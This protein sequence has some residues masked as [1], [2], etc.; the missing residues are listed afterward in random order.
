MV[1]ATARSGSNLLTDGLHAT[2]KAGRPKQFFL[3]KFEG[4]YARRLG[5]DGL[6]FRGYVGGLLEAASTSNR[7]FGFKVMAWYLPEFLDRVK[8]AFGRGETVALP[9][10]RRAFPRLRFIRIRRKNRLQQ[11]ISKARAL[12]SGLWKVQPGAPDESAPPIYNRELISR[13]LEET[14][15]DE[16]RWDE[17]FAREGVVPHTVTYEELCGDYDPTVRSTLRFLGVKL[18]DSASLH[19][20][21]VRQ[22]DALSRE[23]EARYKEE[24]SSANTHA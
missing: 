7:V 5:L 21:T 19:P 15:R 9:A 16:A 11:A 10:L 18:R 2:R 20:V 23:W 14:E 3:E 6:D 24:V 8:A 13:C 1:C 12:Q 22:S 4:E 17:F